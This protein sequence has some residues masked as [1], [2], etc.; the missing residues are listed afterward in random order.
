VTFDPYAERPWKGISFLVLDKARVEV[1]SDRVRLPYCLPSGRVHY[2]RIKTADREW[3]EPKPTE[4]GGLIPFGLE[5]LPWEERDEHFEQ[6]SACLFLCEGESDCLA[7]REGFA[8]W[9]V[10]V[11]DEA[12]RQVGSWPAFP[13]GIYAV[14]LPGALCWRPYWRRYFRRFQTIFLIADAD[15]AGTRMMRTVC[16][17]LPWVRTVMLPDGEDARSILQS[18]GAEGLLLYLDDAERCWRFDAAMRRSDPDPRFAWESFLRIY[19]GLS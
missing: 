5:T 8:D 1:T 4:V 19:R 14:A 11:R 2:W 16:R 17:E 3:Y 7:V 18:S 15:E 13:A 10:I 9:Q 12:G 6:V